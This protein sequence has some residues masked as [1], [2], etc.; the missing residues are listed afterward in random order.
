MHAFVFVPE[1]VRVCMYVCM[2]VPTH[3]GGLGG[4]CVRGEGGGGQI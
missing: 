1:C 2:Y 4:V 3:V